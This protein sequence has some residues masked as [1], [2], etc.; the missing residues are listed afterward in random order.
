MLLVLMISS[1]TL[2]FHLADAIVQYD[3]ATAGMW[4]VARPRLLTRT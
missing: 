4:L 2:P 3:K 1:W